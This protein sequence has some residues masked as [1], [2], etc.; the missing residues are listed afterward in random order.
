MP[1]VRKPEPLV[2]V[3]DDEAVVRRVASLLLETAGFQVVT[4]ADGGEAMGAA[5]DHDVDA[6]LLDV[7]LPGRGGGEVAADLRRVRPDLPIVVSSGH[8]DETMAAEVGPLANVRFVRKPYAADDL[9][10]ALTAAIAA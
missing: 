4:A 2:L 1:G 7:M 6:V 3:V 10:D 9:V 5:A 8:D